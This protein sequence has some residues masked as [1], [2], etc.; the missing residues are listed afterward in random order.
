LPRGSTFTP[1][2][3]GGSSAVFGK[4]IDARQGRAFGD[5]IPKLRGGD[6]TGNR[7]DHQQIEIE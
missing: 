3:L 2:G 7:E 1:G 6:Y 5:G 4:E